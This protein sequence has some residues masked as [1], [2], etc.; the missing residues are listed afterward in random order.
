MIS[1]KQFAMIFSSADDNNPVNKSLDGSE[2]SV[3]LDTPVSFPPD[4]FDCTIEVVQA[5]VWNSVPNISITLNNNKFYVYYGG[6]STL[7]TVTFPDGLYS[8]SSLNSQIS[9]SLI[10]QGAP[11][12][13]VIL[14][15]N[16]STQSVVISFPYVGSYV[17]FTLPQTCRGVLGFDNRLAPLTPTTIVDQSENADSPAKFN[18]VEYFLLKSDI[19]QGSIP[20]NRVSSDTIALVN[21]TSL[22]GNQ[23]VYT[24]VNPIRVDASSLRNGGKNIVSFRLTD[25]KNK[26]ANTGEP[27]SLTIVFRYSMMIHR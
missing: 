27:Y 4:S 14:T 10:N 2:F 17:D 24:P 22:T 18:N 25:D 13:T 6:D 15:G 26:P 3:I 20:T 5:S 12:D 8:L 11:G 21:I 7:Y 1:K 19:V 9:K 23:T 16:Q